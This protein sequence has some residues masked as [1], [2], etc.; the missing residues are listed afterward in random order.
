[1]EPPIKLVPGSVSTTQLLQYNDIYCVSA[2]T[3][4]LIS[5]SAV[6]FFG[7]QTGFYVKVNKANKAPVTPY[8]APSGQLLC[9]TFGLVRGKSKTVLKHKD[10]DCVKSFAELKVG[11]EH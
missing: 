6:C 3:F 7:F 4:L 5:L 8:Y 2:W 11:A 9:H 1:M 10:G